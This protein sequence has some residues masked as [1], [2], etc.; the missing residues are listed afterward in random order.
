MKCPECV[1][2]GKQ[3]NIYL[4]ALPVTDMAT[5][6]YYD[7]DG[8]YHFHDPNTRATGYDCSNGHSWSEGQKPKCPTC[9]KEVPRV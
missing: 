3:S 8:D 7:K 1:K 9:D 2:E 4:L 6:Q 5:H